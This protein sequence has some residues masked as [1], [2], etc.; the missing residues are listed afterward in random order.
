[1]IKSNIKTQVNYYTLDTQRGSLGLF[2][3]IQKQYY[4]M[5][6]EVYPPVAYYTDI[7][8]FIL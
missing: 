2:K 5:R 7:H 6:S 8:K 1:M 3:L 4:G